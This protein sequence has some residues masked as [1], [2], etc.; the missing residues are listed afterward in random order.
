MSY[1]T[2]KQAIDTQ[3]DEHT[4]RPKLASGLDAQSDWVTNMVAWK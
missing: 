1:R 4:H 2:D 3:T